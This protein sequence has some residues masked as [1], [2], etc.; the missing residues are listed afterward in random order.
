VAL[1]VVQ[2][3]I[4]RLAAAGDPLAVLTAP[5]L[6]WGLAAQALVAG[7]VALL[8]RGARRTVEALS[9]RARRRSAGTVAAAATPA[10]RP[11]GRRRHTP[12]SRRGPPL[13]AAT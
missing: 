5:V 12:A 8:V 6:W 11:T 13:P 9:R 4:E 3:T 2:E 1:F 7:L 10:D